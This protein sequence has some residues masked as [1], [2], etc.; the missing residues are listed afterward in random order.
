MTTLNGF[1]ATAHRLQ[2][3][4]LGAVMAMG[5]VV[6]YLLSIILIVSGIVLQ[7]FIYKPSVFSG[8]MIVV[9]SIVWGIAALCIG[10]LVERMTLGGCSKYRIATERREIIQENFDKIVDPTPETG[11]QYSSDIARENKNRY[12]SAWLIVLGATL[13]IFCEN[14][15]VQY[16]F[17]G[18]T[19]MQI[20][21][22]SIP[23]GTIGSLFLSGLVS[24][25][26][27]S[28][29]LHKK[30]ESDV[31]HE[32][33]TA[34]SFL[35]TATRADVT[36]RVYQQMLKRSSTKVDEISESE[37]IDSAFEQAVLQDIDS[38]LDGKGTI[39]LRIDNERRQKEMQIE[40]DK[41]RTRQQLRLLKGGESTPEED[42][43]GVFYTSQL[44]ITGPIAK[45]PQ[46]TRKMRGDGM[47]NM[48][49]VYSLYKQMG[50]EYFTPDRKEGLSQELGITLR[51]LDR[52]LQ[53]LRTG[54]IITG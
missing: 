30:Q 53:K 16:L 51:S 10:V 36:D 37:T 29:E 47:E 42:T 39:I 38:L 2:R 50:E 18:W 49:R 41:Q 52:I 48:K 27:I 45:V 12:S 1:I 8:A 35:P 46:N 23:I 44:P 22:V 43:E 24:Y 28:S 19:P 31:I 11:R 20:G 32:S 17:T 3:K 25:T 7:A 13:S 26:L 21:P 40:A 5:G 15:V 9:Y 54:E 33:I 14:F 4:T 6:A 34:D